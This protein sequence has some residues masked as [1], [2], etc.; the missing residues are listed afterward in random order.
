[1]TLF[2][3]KLNKIKLEDRR[4]R[5]KLNKNSKN[6]TKDIIKLQISQALEE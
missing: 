5:K 2:F 1:M 6:A 4:E 3:E